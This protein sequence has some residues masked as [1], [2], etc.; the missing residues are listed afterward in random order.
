MRSRQQIL[1]SVLLIILG[2]SILSFGSYN[3][4]YQNSVTEGGVLGLIL[5]IKNIFDISPAITSLI[6]D[7]SLFALGSKFFG[8]KFLLY[9]LVSTATFSITYKTWESIGFLIPSLMNNMLIGSILAGIFVGV[10]VGFV[11]RGGGAAGGDDVIAL[12]GNRFTKLKVNHI[13]L[14][15]DAIVLLLSLVYL[16]FKQVFFSIIAVTISGKIISLIY[17]DNDE[18]DDEGKE[19]NEE[20]VILL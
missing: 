13:Y 12:L 6:I 8:K 19:C 1:K 10:G 17:K 14:I 4:N 5:L 11:V 15:T 3:F 9:S 20:E 2:S 7:V 18:D 16:D